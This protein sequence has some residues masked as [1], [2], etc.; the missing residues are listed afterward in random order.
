M[1]PWEYEG[2]PDLQGALRG[3]ETNAEGKV[4]IEMVTL[5]EQFFRG[6]L[7]IGAFFL[8]FGMLGVGSHD[9][10]MKI[11]LWL[12]GAMTTVGLIAFFAVSVYYL[13]DPV[14]GEME[15]MTEIFNIGITQGVASRNDIVAFGVTE[16]YRSG[17]RNCPSYLQYW[18]VMLLKN[19]DL[20]QITDRSKNT[21]GPPESICR[22]LAEAY[23]VTF[24]E[25]RDGN[26]VV[27]AWDQDTQQ[28]YLE[29][30]KRSWLGEL[31]S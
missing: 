14:T 16:V 25:A 24:M 2:R 4:I 23:G 17:G 7:L 15:K 19:G 22:P 21:C 5:L 11:F 18:G 12:G 29:Y 27:R 20:I 1:E 6:L 30:K 31:F 8:F 13:I 28:Y 9:V 3:F 26:R 10:K